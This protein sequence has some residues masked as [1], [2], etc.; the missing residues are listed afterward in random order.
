MT[1]HVNLN[2]KKVYLPAK[3]TNIYLITKIK[4]KEEKK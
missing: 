2:K 1:V 4:K 3:K